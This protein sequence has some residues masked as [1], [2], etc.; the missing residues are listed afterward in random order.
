MAISASAS[1]AFI[2]GSGIDVATLKLTAASFVATAGLLWLVWLTQ[3]LYLAW[4]ERR[5][6]LMDLHWGLMRAAVLVMALSFAI[7]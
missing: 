7:R 1:S 4:S 5:I 6:S 3:S 2:T